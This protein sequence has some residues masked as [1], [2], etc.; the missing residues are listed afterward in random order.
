MDRSL[1]YFFSDG[2]VNLRLKSSSDAWNPT[3]ASQV[4]F[5]KARLKET[6]VSRSHSRGCGRMA[7]VEPVRP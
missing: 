7:M 5:L 6:D 3:I 1:S 2:V 4:S